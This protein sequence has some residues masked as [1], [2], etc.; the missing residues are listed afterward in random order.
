LLEAVP[1][2]EAPSLNRRFTSQPNPGAF[3]EPSREI[4]LEASGTSSGLAIKGELP[5]CGTRGSLAI[6]VR[7]SKGSLAFMSMEVGKNF[8][9]HGQLAGR[10]VECHPVLGKS[11]A[12]VACWQA[13][14]VPVEAS[15][16]PRSFE[17]VLN[18]SFEKD[19]E[20]TA[21]AHFLPK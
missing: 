5:K 17:F 14:R 15:P 18:S 16:E 1:V 20:L 7:M 3:L 13:W 12:G 19:V 10:D 21:R 9:M 4:A 8:D 11:L 2:G 6:E